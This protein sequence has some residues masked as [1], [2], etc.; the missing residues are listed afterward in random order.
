MGSTGEG[1]G[2]ALI[3]ADTRLDAPPEPVV[4][5][6]TRVVV[7]G[8]GIAG[9][10]AARALH[11]SGIDVVV[12]EGR[13]RI[14][15]RTNTVGLGEAAVDLG[16]SWIH[17][18]AGSPVLPYTDALGIERLPAAPSGIVLGATVVDRGGAAPDEDARAVLT[19]ALAGFVLSRDHIGDVTAGA[20]L[21]TALAELLPDVAAPVRNQLGALLAMYDGADASEVS[22]ATFSS[23]FFAGGVEDQDVLPSGGYRRIVDALADGLTIHTS[24]PVDR[25]HQRGDDVVV[26]AGDAT[27]AASHV[28]V[29]A[30]LGVLKAAAIGFEPELPAAHTA[31]IGRMGFGVFEKVA[32]EYPEPVWQVDGSSSHLTVIDDVERRWPVVLDLSTWYDA[33]VV[34]GMAVGA[35][36]RA[37]AALTEDERVVHLHDVV[38]ALGGPDTPDPIRRVTS[39][40]T[41]DPFSLGCYTNITPDSDPEQQVADITT[42]S[43]PHGRVLFAGEHTNPTG[44]STV[45]S[46]WLSG[47]RE[48]A[49]L[50][51]RTSVPL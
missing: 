47:I 20:D 9:L 32:L 40:W 41:S 3:D 22:F 49:R 43:T 12:L 51:G 34:V 46:A 42:L 4:G 15:G 24:T 50:L 38:R 27:Y 35:H 8:A 39:S 2:A 45:D 44:T 25:V 30:P 29:T 23:F 1:L 37:L 26:H 31:A 5:P 16:A 19:G 36:A 18:G 6:V 17:D 7:V 28:I 14:G 10:T 11:L 48:A 21:E 13:D 33:P